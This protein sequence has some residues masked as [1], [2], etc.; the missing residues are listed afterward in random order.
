MAK[1]KNLPASRQ[2]SKTK[3]QKVPHPSRF[4]RFIASFGVLLF[5]SIALFPS[6]LEK[7]SFDQA[8]ENLLKNPKDQQAHLL[9]A[10]EFLKNNQL[11][12]TKKE[13]DLAQQDNNSKVLG[14]NPS[15]DNIW[16]RW[17][18]LNPVEVQREIIK[19]E[20]FMTQNPTYF[21]GWLILARDY[22]KINQ[23]DKAE[24]AMNQARNLDPN[25]PDLQEFVKMIR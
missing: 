25:S 16:A 8:R 1:V 6:F 24:E 3:K 18:D 19:W 2:G 10:N 11:E 23:P 14:A 5:L 7:N 21:Y 22:Y 13:L 12:Q 9:L 15:T 4:F 17:K 20:G